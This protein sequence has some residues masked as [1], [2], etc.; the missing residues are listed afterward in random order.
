MDIETERAQ[1]FMTLY[2]KEFGNKLTEEEAKLMIQ[3][4]LEFY[5]MILT[6]LPSEE[7]SSTQ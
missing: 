5:Q 3:Q 6:Q 2:K 1:M 4:M 7:T